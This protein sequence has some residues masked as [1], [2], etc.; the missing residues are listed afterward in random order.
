MTF[1]GGGTIGLGTVTLTVVA[2]Q[3]HDGTA[4]T[5]ARLVSSAFRS[6]WFTGTGV[7]WTLLWLEFDQNGKIGATSINHVANTASK[8]HRIHWII[9]HD[10]VNTSGSNHLIGFHSGI[11][12]LVLSNSILYNFDQQ[13][14]GN[15][16]GYAISVTQGSGIPTSIY[17]VTIHNVKATNGPARGIQ[18]SDFS[19]KTIKNTIVTDVT[20]S[21]TGT[22]KC[23][24]VDAPVAA[25]LSHNAA[26][27]TSASGTGSL[28]SI[29]AADE[30][31]STVAGSE[32]LHLKAGAD[33]I[34]AG[35]DLGTTPTGVNFDIDGYDRDAGGVTWDIGA[36]EFVSVDITLSPSSIS[37]GE[38]FGTT[39]IELVISQTSISSAETFGTLTLATDWIVSS[40]GISSDEAFGTSVITLDI[41]LSGIPSSEAFGTSLITLS[42]ETT[43]IASQEAFGSHTLELIIS[44]SG[45]A[46]TE[47]FGT[48]S[49]ELAILLSSIPSSEAFGST[50]LTADWLI[51]CNG[52]PTTENF[53]SHTVSEEAALQISPSAIASQESVPS[54]QINF[55]ILLTSISSLEAF[56]NPT[57]EI[58]IICSS[59]SSQES[60]GTP[61]LTFTII[62][63]SISSLENVS[64]PALSII[65]I[66]SSI[67]SGEVFGDATILV[68][69][70]ITVLGIVS[71]EVFGLPIIIISSDQVLEGIIDLMPRYDIELHNKAKYDTILDIQPAA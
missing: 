34:D 46:S 20:E 1:N 64:N 43:S 69:L 50:T 40:T 59:I 29:V 42:I 7:N 51:N 71:G 21:G 27:D 67:T 57:F 30:F 70:L 38:A 6:F 31:V 25:V 39:L 15:N 37:S 22:A 48:P 66:C 61:S 62:V 32:D 10:H 60:F 35:T 58:S 63:S 2:G 4:G 65:I 13:H 28:D 8:N 26:S 19:D 56:G 23:F 3:R 41:S 16:T 53:G 54:P 24:Q 33:C 44:A 17:N 11:P 5:G 9:L 18:H 52:I 14:V 36:D 55:A 45:I 68:D 12:P 47:T 49:L